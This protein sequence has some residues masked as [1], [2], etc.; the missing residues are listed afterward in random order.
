MW[1]FG[2]FL[3]EEKRPLEKN[4]YN[5]KIISNIHITSMTPTSSQIFINNFKI[6]IVCYMFLLL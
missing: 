2:S 3:N 6:I 1:I 5:R 4:V